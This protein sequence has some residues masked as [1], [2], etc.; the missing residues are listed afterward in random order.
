MSNHDFQ[1]LKRPVNDLNRL[2]NFDRAIESYELFRTHSRLECGHNIFRQR[3]Q[4]IP[5]VDNPS[6]SVRAL[7]GATLD[8]ID[9]FCEQISR[10]HGLYKPNRSPLSHPSEAQSRRETLDAKLTP[11]RGRGQMLPLWLRPKTEPDRLR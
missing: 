9:K 2:A 8:R 3:C 1:S 4:P 7:N 5:K 6:D 10:K 11:E